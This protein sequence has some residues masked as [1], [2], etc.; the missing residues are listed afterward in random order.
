[1]RSR[2]VEKGELYRG[3]HVRLDLGMTM[4]GALTQGV[5]YVLKPGLA[6]RPVVKEFL[7][8]VRFRRED[9][10]TVVKE[11]MEYGTQERLSQMARK[12]PLPKIVD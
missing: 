8:C 1:M 6:S 4:V 2:T 12:F 10:L 11:V 9:N 3:R 7:S 5:V